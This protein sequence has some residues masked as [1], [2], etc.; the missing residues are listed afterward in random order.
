MNLKNQLPPRYRL[1]RY[2]AVAYMLLI[3]YASLTPFAG[4]REQGLNFIDVLFAPLNQTF[5]WFDAIL[6]CI[7]Y[8]PFGF[9]L[10]YMQRNHWSAAYVLILATFTGL[11][12]STAMEFAQLFLPVRVSSN[13][14]LL[15]NTLGSFCGAVI[16]VTITRYTWFMRIKTW[17][18]QWLKAD[19]ATDFG[20]ALLVLW[21]FA[22]VNPTLP[23]LGSVFVSAIARWRFDIVKAD[24]FNWLECAEVTLNMLL[25]GILILTLMRDRRHT[26]SALL[27]VLVTITLIKFIAAATLL[28]SWAL[29]LWLD[30]EAILGIISGFLL[31]LAVMKAPPAWLLKVSGLAAIF[32]LMAVLNL[33]HSSSPSTVMRL[34]HW[35]YAHLLNYTGLSQLINLVFPVLL[36]GYLWRTVNRS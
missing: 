5:T 9:F 11:A 16:A 18:E 10:A 6:N 22:Q 36:L 17:H 21:M 30:S 27:G 26:L 32:Y 13:I 29:L 12:V 14:D 25:L 15:S 19:K 2:L 8:L 34:Y 23:M 3:V 24:P 4:W 28:K 7:S 33:F 31:L 35:H 1:H 20:L